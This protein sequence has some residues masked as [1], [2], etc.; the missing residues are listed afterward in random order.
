MYI[1]GE[2]VTF[3]NGFGVNSPTE[4]Y[5]DVSGLNIERLQGYAG[6]DVDKQK[7]QDGCYAVIRAD[8]EE[9]YRSDLLTH[10]KDAAY[11]DIDVTGVKELCLYVDQNI[12]DGHDMVSWCD[13]KVILQGFYE[14]PVQ[15]ELKDTATVRLDAKKKILYNVAPG[16]TEAQLREMFALPEG[17]TFEMEDPYNAQEP[18]TAQAAT[19]YLAK[20]YM[21]GTVKD[22]LRIAVNGDVDGSA[23]GRIDVADLNKLREALAGNETLD[24]LNTYAADAN[25]DGAVDIKD[26]A[27]AVKASGIDITG[28]KE[29]MTWSL[30]AVDTTNTEGGTVSI[31]GA[32]LQTSS[33]TK[34]AMS[35]GAFVLNYDDAVYEAGD[36][37]LAEGVKGS[38][39][40]KKSA[41]A[42]KVVYNLTEAVN[43]SGDLFQAV[44]TLADGA[45][46]KETEFTVSGLSV[47][48]ADQSLL[49]TASQGTNVTPGGAA[50]VVNVTG[51]K[52]TGIPQTITPDQTFT[53]TAEVAPA[54]A[55]EK[56]VTWTSSDAKVATVDENGNVC[57]IGNG[58][59]AITATTKEAESSVAQTAEI[60][61]SSEYS[62]MSYSYLT[63]Q[64]SAEKKI[65]GTDTPESDDYG[66]IF[67]DTAASS[68]GWGGFHVNEANSA[69]GTGE[70][71]TNTGISMKINGLQTAFDQ[72]LSANTNCTMKF[73]LTGLNAKRLQTWVG[74][75]WVKSTKTGRDGADFRFYKDSIAE[76]NSLHDSIAIGQQ[77]NAKFV[78]IDLT[79]VTTLVIYVDKVGTNSDDC[80]DLADAKVYCEGTSGASL[81][82]N[83]VNPVKASAP[84]QS[85]SSEKITGRAGTEEITWTS[86]D[87]AIATVKNGVV[88][89][90]KAGKTTIIAQY[91]NMRARCTVEVTKEAQV[92][93]TVTFDADNGTEPVSVTVAQ[94]AKVEK[95]E[96][97]KKDGFVFA[98][99]FAEG[100][101][102]AFDFET[103][104]TADL[105]LT[106]KWISA[107]NACTVI[108]QNGTDSQSEVVEKGQTVAKPDDPKKFGHTFLGWFAEGEEKAFDFET[109]ITA[110]LTLTAKW[111]K[112]SSKVDDYEALG[113]AI[114]AAEELDAS[115][116]TAE[117]WA[118]LQK[119]LADAK[120]KAESPTA[121]QEEID[122]AKE[123]V[124]A[125]VKA[126]EKEGGTPSVSHTVT[127]DADNGSD[128]ITQTI[129]DG[130]KAAKPEEPKKFGHTFQGWFAGN[131]SEAFDF[132]TAITADLTLTAKWE[133]ISAKVDD[134]TALGETIAAAEKLNASEYT[135]E[136]W[137]KLQQAL[138]DAKAKAESPTATQEEIDAA[139]AA[140]EA[141]VKALTKPGE[142]VSFT[143]TFDADNGSAVTTQTVTQGSTVQKPADPVKAGYTFT[144]WYAPGAAA[145][146]DFT[147]IITS[148]LTLTAKWV[149]N[150]PV[151]TPV[152]IASAKVKVAN[153]TYNGK[154]RKPAVTVT[155]N[156]TK[157][158]LNTD[159]KVTYS[160]NKKV[161]QGKVKIT[162]TGAYTGTKNAVF[163]IL[164]KASKVTKITNKAGRKLVLKI[165]KSTGAKGYEITYATNKKFKSAKKIKSKKTTVTL[166]KLKK[167]KTYYVKVRAYAK[168]GKKTIYSKTY[169]KT[170]K[171]KVKK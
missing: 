114:A 21:D 11:F 39:S 14:K 2:P 163:D 24:D 154:Q 167:N 48:A 130:E 171:K 78:D 162:G 166:K 127:F 122:A 129:T 61:V 93:Y 133:K 146:F 148:D 169:S 86:A 13:T 66:R 92:N 29:D 99:W 147:T 132:D 94:G 112:I 55:T 31:T 144:G 76:E 7:T 125:A 68:S 138:A 83:A 104:V 142:T 106:A 113:A 72:G 95:P 8:G 90:V 137:A 34:S 84:A 18:D 105:T 98:G 156:G 41:G 38:I 123:A 57:A 170:V 124:E 28:A 5:F 45:L 74:I 141:A 22:T 60:T 160:N 135:E 115:E 87:P 153:I 42:V 155:Y 139:K 111:Q 49:T 103:P 27:A 145:A 16:T 47:A 101:E 35:A 143:V 121:T 23:D 54:N 64:V 80:I 40:V 102:K 1:D 88:T 128:H 81:S 71:T 65:F 63:A 109:A 77:D 140:V 58:T 50:G 6:I 56:G 161:G 108:F 107:V 59:A 79:G 36:V 62:S 43:V 100:E 53:L 25:Q 44:F 136:S 9:V 70:V 117:S 52:I 119:A 46:Q 75:D 97:P 152:S 96:E 85:A 91:Q 151:T 116:Y 3:E 69:S 4:L 168:S 33:E 32:I 67:L 158:K 149:K 157:L 134:Y 118:N 110:D 30:S 51:I 10:G 150:A 131:A 164:P 20:L 165:K 17:G 73:D 126:L 19:G 120:A 37:A 89:G 15:L 159:Y 26:L 82:K 12:K